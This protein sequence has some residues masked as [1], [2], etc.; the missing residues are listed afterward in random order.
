MA[1]QI[2][3]IF[4]SHVHEDD[5]GLAELKSLVAK[6]GLTIR[7][8]SVNADNPNNAKSPEYIKTSILAPRIQDCATMVVYIS[9]KT[10]E[11]AWVG[12]EIEHAE[13]NGLRIVGVWAHGEKG[14]EIPRAL[15]DFA[16]AVVGWHGNSII[17]AI[18]GKNGWENPDGSMRGPRE[19]KR[20]EC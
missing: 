5:A 15:E 2:K 8:Y 19:I 11:S 4:I 20:A 7:D 14:C 12:W 6:N 13:R 16:D 18:N 3:N 17:D 10:K 1:G 9:P